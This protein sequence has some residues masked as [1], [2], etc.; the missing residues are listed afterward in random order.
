MT[1]RLGLAAAV[2]VAI[3]VLGLRW[4]ASRTVSEIGFSFAD[5]PYTL[6]DSLARQLGGA[7]TGQEMDNLR[8]LSRTEVERA[9][10]GL[11]LRVTAR[12]DAFWSVRVVPS[13]PAVGSRR[14][15]AGG[16]TLALGILGGKGLVDFTELAATAIVHAPEGASRQTIVDG[17]G[18]GIGRSAVHEFAHAILGVTSTMDVATDEASYEHESFNRPGQYYGELHWAGAWPLLEREV[19]R[20]TP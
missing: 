20:M 12:P 15:P 17:I 16:Q 1:R 13:I 19:G 7:L 5:G 3:L 8:R 18:R 10:S 4:Y 2:M 6:D 9:F 14:G 11:R